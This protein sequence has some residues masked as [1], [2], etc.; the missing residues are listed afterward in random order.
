MDEF[1]QLMHSYLKQEVNHF[2][3][4]RELESFIN[5]FFRNGIFI[6]DQMLFTD[7]VSGVEDYL[8]DM[9]EYQ[10]HD[11]DVFEDLDEYVYR[12]FFGDTYAK[13][14]GPS[15]PLQ[16]PTSKSKEDSLL[17]HQRK[18]QRAHSRPN[19]EKKWS[20]PGHTNRRHIANVKIELGPL[21]FDPK[22]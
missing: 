18:H 17:G 1:N 7:F 8:E 19:R 20:R 4:W 2:H 11:D 13:R 10:S 16:K 9:N 6:H 15:K 5:N 22:Y 21:P 3:H 12:H 14:Y